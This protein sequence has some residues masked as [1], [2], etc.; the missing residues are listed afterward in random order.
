MVEEEEQEPC[1]TELEQPRI[2]QT[3]TN[4]VGYF[5]N[6]VRHTKI[7]CLI[8]ERK[9]NI[10]AQP[11]FRGG[12]LA[13][14]ISKFVMRLSRRH[15][16]Q[17]R[18]SDGGVHWDTVHSRLIK[19]FGSRGGRHF[20][21]RDWHQEICEG[22]NKTRFECCLNTKGSLLTSVQFKTHWWEHDCTGTGGSCHNSVQL[23]RVC[24]PQRMWSVLEKGLIAG[25]SKGE[26]QTIFFTPLNP[27]WRKSDEKDASDDLPESRKVHCCNN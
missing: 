11:S 18:D 9:W 25:D 27:F 10:P 24:V 6:P 4:G 14:T 22:S 19:E 17:E 23:E 16:Q 21:D 2:E 3:H 12:T 7:T 1:S 15:D 5:A 20:S 8:K 26:R 13:T